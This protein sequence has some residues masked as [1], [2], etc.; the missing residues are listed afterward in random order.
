MNLLNGWYIDELTSY[1]KLTEQ[2]PDIQIQKKSLLKYGFRGFFLNDKDD[3]ENS[4]WFDNYIKGERVEFLV[5]GSGTYYISNM[6]LASREIYFTSINILPS[7]P[8]KIFFCYQSDYTESNEIISGLLEE[9]VEEINDK[10]VPIEPIEIE[11]ASSYGEG[12]VKIDSN[13]MKKI[14]KSVIFLADVTPVLKF[15]EDNKNKAYPNPNVCIEVGYALKSKTE[16]RVVLCKYERDDFEE[17]NFPFDIDKNRRFMSSD[18]S[19]LKTEIKKELTE[20]LSEYRIIE[21]S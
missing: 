8:P 16:D 14:K 1:D 15:D 12:A 20:K 13:L 5:E 2:E 11:R 6:D 19:E 9:I 3:V 7:L 10:Y 18:K 17:V 4:E 21:S